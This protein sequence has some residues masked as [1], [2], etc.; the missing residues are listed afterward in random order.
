MGAINNESKAAT[1]CTWTLQP[2]GRNEQLSG[3]QAHLPRPQLNAMK[4]AKHWAQLEAGTLSV[5]C[6]KLS[7]ELSSGYRRQFA[8]LLAKKNNFN[9]RFALLREE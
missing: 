9:D 2:R 3:C 8:K 5:F 1:I 4:T 7:S 6:F